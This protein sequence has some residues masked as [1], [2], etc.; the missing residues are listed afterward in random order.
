MTIKE[1]TI[2][3]IATLN[4][5]G[6]IASGPDVAPLK[7]RI[8]ELAKKDINQVVVDVSEVSWIGSAMLGVLA[9]G[10][11]TT[12]AAGGDLRLTGVNKQIASALRVTKLDT[13]F[14]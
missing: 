1:T 6:R 10:L 8:Q 7:F 11:V 2:E 14:V 13:V 9:N 4:V 3:T 12:R 5:S